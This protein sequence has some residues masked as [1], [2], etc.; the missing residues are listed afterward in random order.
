MSNYHLKLRLVAVFNSSLLTPF[1]LGG[2][3]E[4]RLRNK[5]HLMCVQL[6]KWKVPLDC[7]EYGCSLYDIIQMLKGMLCVSVRKNKS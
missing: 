3:E 2:S 6:W 7:V 5:Q 1:T 4:Q